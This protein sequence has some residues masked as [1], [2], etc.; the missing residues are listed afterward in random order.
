M[1]LNRWLR[2]AVLVVAVCLSALCFAWCGVSWRLERAGGF[3]EASALGVNLTDTVVEETPS[4]IGKRL[5]SY[6]I[7]KEIG[8]G[9]MG[10]VYLATHNVLEKQIAE[11]DVR[12]AVGHRRAARLGHALLV[13]FVRAR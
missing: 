12:K 4:V 6:K 1:R 13:D 3:M 7:V 11:R 10:S 5:G 8:R 2:G 9:G